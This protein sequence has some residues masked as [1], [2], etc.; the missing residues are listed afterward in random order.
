MHESAPQ[1]SP[2]QTFSVIKV[3]ARRNKP[4]IELVL[5]TVSSTADARKALLLGTWDNPENLS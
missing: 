5:G 2:K 4:E 3:V 1:L